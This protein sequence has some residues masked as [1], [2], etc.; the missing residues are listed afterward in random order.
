MKISIGCDHGGFAMKQQVISLLTEQGVEIEDVGCPDTT[1]VDYTEYASAVSMSVLSGEVDEGILICTTGIGMSMAANRYNHIRAALCLNGEMAEK[2]HLHNDANILVLAA[3][4]TSDEMLKEI[5]ASWSSHTFVPVERHQRRIDN[6]ELEE[7][8]F[9]DMAA[10]CPVD[11]EIFSAIEA[12]IVRED[13][14][15]N[16]I[17]SENTVSRAVRQA[18]GSMMTNKYAEGYPGKRYYSGCE[19]VDDA[20]ALAI[21]RAKELFGAEHV[22]V[23]AHCGSSANMGVYFSVLKPGDT[24]MAMSLDHGG[25]LTHGH[26]VNFS[27]KLY[28]IVSY[29]VNRETEKLDYDEL[30]AIAKQ[31]KPK[32]IVAGASAYSRILDFPKFREIA[33]AVGA[34]LMVDMAHIAGLVA[35]GIH[36]SPVPH[37]DF[38]TTTTHKTLRGPRGGMIL[39]KEQFAKDLD[40]TIFPG[41]QGGPLMHVIAAK[42]ICFLEAMEPEFKLYAGQVVANAARLAEILSGEGFR[43]VSGGTDTHLLLVDVGASGMTGKDAANALDAAG[44]I[45]NKNTVPFDSQSPFVTSGVRIGTATVTSRGMEVEEMELIGNMICRIL[46]DPTNKALQASIAIEVRDLGRRFPVE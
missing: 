36:P 38:V 11:P 41:I 30:M 45:T 28:N 10:I 35:A 14:T 2:A 25:H 44:I 27:G 24:I 42:A 43:V 46:K 32:I 13:E 5:L 9:S 15:I 26:K 40:R 16:L 17:A 1:S 34:Y 20:E 29:G 37:A 33:D 23:Q 3:A 31:S 7:D 8:K 6:M 4:Q 22:N 12:E 19:C 39:C 18:Q 21:S